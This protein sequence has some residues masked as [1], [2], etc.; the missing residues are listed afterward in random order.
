MALGLNAQMRPGLLEGGLQLPPL[1][2]PAQDL[3]RVLIGIGA[4][5]GL[6]VEPAQRVTH[7]HPPDRHDGQSGMAPDRGAG[8]QLNRALAPATPARHQNVPPDRARID[9]HPGQVRQPLALGS[10][11]SEGSGQ[12]RRCRII[13]GGIKA[14]AGD[15]D[16]PMAGKSGQE[17]Q[18]GEAAVGN[19]HQLASRQPPACLQDHLPAPLGE[20]FV[21][22]AGLAVVSFG[23]GQR[24]QKRQRPDALRPG[25]RHQQ[26][27]A[28]P[29]QAGRLD[30]MPVAGADRVAINAFGGDALAAATLDRVVEPE[31]HG[32]VRR[33]R[34]DQQPQQQPGG[35]PRAPGRSAQHPVVVHKVPLTH[36]TADPQQAGH[37]AR[38]RSEN[39][40]NQQHLGRAPAPMVKQRCEAQDDRGEAGGQDGH[41]GVSWR[42][43]ASHN[44]QIA[45]PLNPA[46]IGQ[47]RAQETLK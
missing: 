24:G 41:R 30:E 17:I 38:P 9:E 2:E 47:S 35:E 7:Q 33:E 21:P 12:T 14:Q 32:A 20:L 5:Q 25:D 28:E 36:Q 34:L 1:N 15:A 42:G 19:Q 22:P 39:G 18:G 40:A 44:G 46:A 43:H 16:D 23:G 13:K 6:R 37:G 31:H 26:H 29:A 27:H 45:P 10:R 11:T 8:A 3:L 4:E